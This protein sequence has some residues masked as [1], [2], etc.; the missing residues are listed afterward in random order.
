[1]LLAFGPG[2]CCVPKALWGLLAKAVMPWG[3]RPKSPFSEMRAASHLPLGS[4][5]HVCWSGMLR[6]HGHSQIM[7]QP[8]VGLVRRSSLLVLREML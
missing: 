7:Y 5:L 6:C 2:P 3:A 1:M 8:L 4:H